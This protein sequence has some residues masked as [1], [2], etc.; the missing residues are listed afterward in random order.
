MVVPVL[1]THLDRNQQAEY[2]SDAE[3][4]ITGDNLPYFCNPFAKA[5]TPKPIHIQNA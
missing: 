5:A 2:R 4:A 1:R 3:P